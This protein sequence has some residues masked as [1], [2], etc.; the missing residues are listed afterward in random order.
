MDVVPDT[1]KTDRLLL[2]PWRFDDVTDVLAYASDPAWGRFLPV[3]DPYL[4]AHAQEFVA[5]QILLGPP[6]H[7]AWAVEHDGHVVGGVNL[8]LFRGLR[9]GELGYSIARA[10]WGR[11]FATEVVRAV[12]DAAFAHLPGLVRMRAS[13]HPDNGASLR[14]M[15]KVGMQREGVLRSDSFLR[16]LPVDEAWCGILRGEWEA[17]SPRSSPSST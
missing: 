12:I 9:I 2:R 1:L 11:G 3:P 10:S 6:E 16:D 14:V 4:P 5:A 8:R 15:E 17:R 13:A 7:R